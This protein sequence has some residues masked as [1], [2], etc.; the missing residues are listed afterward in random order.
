MAE[1]HNTTNISREQLLAYETSMQQEM[2]T[3]LADIDEI[4]QDQCFTP[5]EDELPD[6]LTLTTTKAYAAVHNKFAEHGVSLLASLSSLLA[7]V[8]GFQPTWCSSC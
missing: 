1:T 3:V 7:L 6:Q 5:V 8:T 4:S 2:E